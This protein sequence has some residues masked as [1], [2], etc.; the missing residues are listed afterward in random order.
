MESQSDRR[1]VRAVQAPA[2]GLP[3][4]LVVHGDAATLGAIESSLESLPV[5]VVV[6]ASPE[7]ALRWVA[8]GA[9]ALI[10][11]D[12]RMAEQDGDA[13][14][15]LV[16][17]QSERR[18]PIIFVTAYDRADT[19]ILRGY[20]AGGVD[21]IFTPIA[22]TILRAKVAAVLDLVAAQS[23]AAGRLDRLRTADAA[24]HGSGRGAHGAPRIDAVQLLEVAM[25]QTKGVAGVFKGYLSMLE[26]GDL[27]TLPEPAAIAMAALNAK[28]DELDRLARAAIAVTRTDSGE[29]LPARQPLDLAAAC[30]EACRRAEPSAIL[31]GGSVTC[32]LRERPIPVEVDPNHLEWILDNLVCNAI[33]HGGQRPEITVTAMASPEPM[34][35][36]QDGGPGIAAELRE[37]IFDPY[38]KGDGDLSGTGLGLYLARTLAEVNGA[39]VELL[40]SAIGEGSTFA[41]IFQSRQP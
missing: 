32:E 8:T 9:F 24:V 11:L 25:H 12:V 2:R 21:Y 14:A 34:V 7:E 22:S 4:V 6:A 10:L 15:Q 28:A 27:G 17:E 13:T 35:L 38:R 30:A 40:R 16:R 31:A 18:T 26:S 29:V 1:T 5:R 41:A 33:A 3:S 36:I 19:D 37:A 20:A 23:E 39:R